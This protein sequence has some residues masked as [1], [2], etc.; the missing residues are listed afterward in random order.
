L[1]GSW[2]ASIVVHAL[3][4]VPVRELA[5][6][7]MK[8][9]FD[10][11]TPPVQVVNLSRDAWAQSMRAAE[12]VAQRR[13][14]PRPGAEP[15]ARA[16]EPEPA[17]PEPPSPPEPARPDGQIVDVP[18]TKDDRP[19]P[20]AR[21]VG[22]HNSRVEKESVARLDARDHTKQRRTNEL[23]D[24]RS[25]PRPDSQKTLG[26]TVQG[27]T[28]GQPG[29][30]NAD[31][32]GTGEDEQ[33]FRL[34]LPDF[35]RRDAVKLKLSDLPG[36]KQSVQNRAQS[37]KL[38]GN[39]QQF[40]FQPGSPD[41][42]GAGAKKGA[43][44]KGGIPSLE[45]LQANLG[46]VARIS[47]SPSL[48]YVENVP[49]GDGTYLNTK[50]FKYATFFIRVKDSVQNYWIDNF[51]REFR[52]RDA[53]GRVFGTR[54]RITLLTIVLDNQGELASVRVAESS[55]L[56]FLDDAAVQAFRQAQPF[57]NPPQGIVEADGTIRFNFQFVVVLRG[58][59]VFD[60][61][62]Y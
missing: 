44:G 37:D 47:G 60:N 6:A 24:R 25:Q 17:A 55:G 16:P 62:G 30:A 29:D 5:Q 38:Q 12:Q 23:Q 39:S 56:D 61:F 57:P 50:E 15:R 20:D 3:L 33:Q 4:F 14:R 7:Y 11:E 43:A 8:P 28:E 36:F 32:K 49:E 13:P 22:E 41:G 53:S 26:L 54:D 40:R 10:P 21:F 45:A 18:P 9:S 1:L 58:G 31:D 35:K 48:D 42:T 59:S 27:E 2:L 46:T 51:R 19:N 52:R 34:E